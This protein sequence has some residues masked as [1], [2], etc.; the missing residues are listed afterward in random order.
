MYTTTAAFSFTTIADRNTQQKHHKAGNENIKTVNV[1]L[2]LSKLSVFGPIFTQEQCLN[3][4]V[5]SGNS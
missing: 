1:N 3:Q 2:N 4:R 5:G